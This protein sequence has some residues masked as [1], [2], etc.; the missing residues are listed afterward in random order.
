VPREKYPIYRYRFFNNGPK[1][2]LSKKSSFWV[3]LFGINLATPL[4]MSYT[5]TYIH[6]CM[7]LYLLDHFVLNFLFFKVYFLSSRPRFVTFSIFPTAYTCFYL[8]ICVY[9]RIFYIYVPFLYFWTFLHC[10]FGDTLYLCV[11]CV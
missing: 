1:S 6:A 3:K 2:L 10:S 9:K 8:P 4:F 5:R 7:I 11:T